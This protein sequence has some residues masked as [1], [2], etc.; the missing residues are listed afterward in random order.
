MHVLTM[1]ELK[2]EGLS[3]SDLNVNLKDSIKCI[4][5][6]VI[7]LNNSSVSHNLNY[8]RHHIPFFL[9]TYLLHSCLMI[10]K[11]W[12]CATSIHL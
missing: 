7:F 9:M 12:W 11:E 6:C 5:Q 1:Q 8:L 4:V 10:L 3:Q 2:F